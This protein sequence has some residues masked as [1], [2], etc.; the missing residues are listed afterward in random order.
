MNELN[1]RRLSLILLISCTLSVITA[2]PYTLTTQGEI[3]ALIPIPLYFLLPLQ[4]LQ[5]VLLFAFFIYAGLRL[6][7]RVGLGVPFLEQLLSDEA[8]HVQPRSQFTLALLSGILVGF[9]ILLS[10]IVLASTIGNIEL[11]KAYPGQPTPPVWQIILVLPYGA[12][13]EEVALRLFAM[14]AF[15]WIIQRLQTASNE[16]PTKAGMWLSIIIA[17]ILFGASHLPTV[18][19]FADLSVLHILRIVFLNTI[20]GVVFGWLYWRR[21]LEHAMVSHF[22]MDLV[23]HIILPPFL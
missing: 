20:G 4:I 10:D 3:L 13:A 8:V 19:F 18:L 14:S 6:S 22:G 1:S 7:Q 16:N 11:L 23:L 12:I 2:L 9:L 5:N 21:G 17:A 15:A